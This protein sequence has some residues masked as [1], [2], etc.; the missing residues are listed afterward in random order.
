MSL[1]VLVILGLVMGLVFGLALEKSRV[2]EPAALVGQF[3][4]RRFVML[5]VFLSAV[6]TG[7]VVVS[8]MQ[9]AGVAELHPKATYLGANLLG[10]ALLGVGIAVA[11]AC[12]GTVLAQIG[13]GY[14]DAWAVLAGALAGTLAYG[15]AQPALAPV[16]FGD[17]LGKVVLSEALGV[18]FWAMAL[19]L[20][21]LL[22]AGM[23]V[24]ERWR[25]W[26][27]EL[28]PDYSLVEPAK[29]AGP[30]PVEGHGTDPGHGQHH[31][32]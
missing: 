6:A 2:F 4:F 28:G 26:R 18:P 14:R 13:A 12:P 15:Y 25:P 16:F 31:P 20:A 30:R 3:Q 9:L 8:V 10:G 7:L 32:A 22:V 29:P 24:L 21:L 1:I 5:K 19:G 11:G 23:V 27:T 17:G